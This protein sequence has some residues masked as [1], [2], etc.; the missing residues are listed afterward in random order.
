[1]K[2]GTVFSLVSYIY[3]YPEG[4]KMCNKSIGYVS[5]SISSSTA[6][7]STE[8]HYSALP[9][10]FVQHR[11]MEDL[12]VGVS[13][14]L[15]YISS[16]AI[17]DGKIKSDKDS[18]VYRLMETRNVA[19]SRIGNAFEPRSNKNSANSCSSKKVVKG[20]VKRF[21]TRP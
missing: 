15:L 9:G 16:R 18:L 21:Y 3:N 8:I 13:I 6:T 12:L 10:I 17:P 20:L 1:M 14:T 2:P 11:I 5:S 4:V 19:C 7:E